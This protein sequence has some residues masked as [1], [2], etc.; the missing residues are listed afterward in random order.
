MFE[1]VRALLRRRMA[2]SVLSLAFGQGTSFFLQA[3]Y[4]VLLARLLGV[5]EYGVFAGCYAVVN[6]LTPYTTLG[7][8]LLFIRYVSLDASL[9]KMYW[10]NALTIAASLSSVMA[11]CLY[12]AGPALTGQH[13]PLLFIVLSMANGFF[14]QVSGMAAQVFQ[15][16]EKM[17]MTAILGVLTNLSRFVAVV[18]LFFAWHHANAYQWGLGVLFSSAATALVAQIF[19]GREIG[20]PRVDFGVIFRSVGEGIGFS[21]AGTTQAVYNDIDKTMLSHYGFTTQNGFY[22]LAYR[23]VDFATAPIA[24][25]DIALLP[26]YFRI[27][28][29]S[30]KSVLRRVIKSLKVTVLSGVAVAL[31]TLLASPLVPFAAGK[32]FAEA[33]VVLRWL[34]WLPILRGIHRMAGIALTGTGH[35]F[36]RTLSQCAVAIFNVICNWLWIPRYGWLGAAW[37]SLASDGLLCVLNLILLYQI[38]RQSKDGE[39][40]PVDILRDLPE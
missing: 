10:G 27:Q 13:V 4:F 33:V 35:Q 19:V 6:A 29:D 32:S 3:M 20:W 7:G 16:Y 1:A 17:Q 34:C 5:R 38:T 12:F 26:G 2:K 22:S 11:L 24:A 37:A 25:L 30:Y 21:F 8:G 40:G 18:I 28:E 36:R 31:L 9:A 14:A 23:I 15:T 39:G